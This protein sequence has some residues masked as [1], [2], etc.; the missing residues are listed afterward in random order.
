ME[1]A[2][3]VNPML[4]LTWMEAKLGEEMVDSTEGRISLSEFQN[5]K[6]EKKEHS[7]H[8]YTWH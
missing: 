2:E 8:A 3:G 6:E 4:W 7:V 5:L 1:Y